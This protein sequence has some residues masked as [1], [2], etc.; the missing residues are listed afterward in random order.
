MD[1][2][3]GL[4]HVGDGDSRHPAFFIGEQNVI[5]TGARLEPAAADRFQRG[6]AATAYFKQ[7][8][9]ER[10]REHAQKALTIGKDDANGTSFLL[11]KCLAALGRKTEAIAAFQAFLAQQPASDLTKSAQAML[12]RLQAT[13]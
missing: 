10:G 1:Y 4:I 8:D 2:T 9:Y 12:A 3:V 11:G 7:A 13:P 6:C 5:A